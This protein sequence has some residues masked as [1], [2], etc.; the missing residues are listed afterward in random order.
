VKR[1]PVA[2]C[3]LVFLAIAAPWFLM[4]NKAHGAG[5]I[6]DFFG[7][8]NINRFLEAEH[9]IGSQWYYNIPVIFGGFFPWSV[10]LPAG[11]W[12]AFKKSTEYRVQ[13]T[14]KKNSV[15]LLVWFAVVFLFFSV[16]S[17][18]LPTYIF[19]CFMSLAIITAVFWDDFLNKSSD[20][21]C[22][23]QMKISFGILIAIII[24]GSFI[25]PLAIRYKYPVLS[26]DI[27]ISAM[28]LVFGVLVSASAFMKR[29][30]VAAFFMVIYAVAIFLYPVSRLVLPE[31]EPLES[32]KAVALKLKSMMKP[33][34]A[35]GGES[36]Y[37]AGLAFYADKFP[38]DLDKHHNLVQFVRSKGRVWGVLKEKNHIQLYTLDTKPYCTV[39]TYMIFKVGKRAVFTNDVPEGVK[40]IVKRERI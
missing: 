9:A 30:Y 29:R 22:R 17:T 15:F 33:D 28:I 18:K 10:F 32:S 11:L 25:A 13:S 39:P 34:E 5:F 31:L 26:N 24:L 3:V 16:S 37:L 12:R 38:V 21:S 8:R 7:F 35:I 40:Y 4:M 36:N 2:G 6:N 20:A 23:R 19:P 27:F 14:E 1:I